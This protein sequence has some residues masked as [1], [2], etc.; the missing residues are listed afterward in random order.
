[1]TAIDQHSPDDRCFFCASDAE[2]MQTLTGPNSRTVHMDLAE[3]CCPFWAPG[4]FADPRGRSDSPT[5]PVSPVSPAADLEE[6][7]RG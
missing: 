4:E 1:V 2:V 5:A 6:G 7:D 3:D